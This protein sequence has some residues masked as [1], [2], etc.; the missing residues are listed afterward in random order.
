SAS[1]TCFA[2]FIAAATAAWA[3]VAWAEAT[4]VVSNRP[5]AANRINVPMERMFLLTKKGFHE[6]RNG[7]YANALDEQKVTYAPSF[8]AKKAAACPMSSTEPSR[9]PSRSP[10]TPVVSDSGSAP[11]PFHIHPTIADATKCEGV[12]VRGIDRR[13]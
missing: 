5:A 4:L 6:R 9:G 7:N 12:I 3:F 2:P 10:R 11:G 1:A 13:R 8:E